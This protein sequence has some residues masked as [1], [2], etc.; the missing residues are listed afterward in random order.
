[1]GG[2]AD[3]GNGVDGGGPLTVDGTASYIDGVGGPG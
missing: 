2:P 3:G 1:M